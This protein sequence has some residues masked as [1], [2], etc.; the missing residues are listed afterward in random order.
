M[1]RS[2]AYKKDS[3]D[4]KTVEPSFDSLIVITF[5]WSSKPDLGSCSRIDLLVSAIL[6]K[7]THPGKNE[8]VSSLRFGLSV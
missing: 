8:K 2:H 7:R 4:N 3:K 1:A 6:W 5:N